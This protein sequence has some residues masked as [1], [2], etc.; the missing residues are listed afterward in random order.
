MNIYE[1]IMFLF[2]LVMAKLHFQSHMLLKRHF[3]CVMT[4]YKSCCKTMKLHKLK[5]LEEALVLHYKGNYDGIYSTTKCFMNSSY[6]LVWHLLCEYHALITRFTI[7]QYSLTLYRH[8]I[9]WFYDTSIM[10]TKCNGLYFILFY[11]IFLEL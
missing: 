8:I 7:A 5:K 2:I 10:Q 1:H 9:K 4:K 3:G 11:C 6:V